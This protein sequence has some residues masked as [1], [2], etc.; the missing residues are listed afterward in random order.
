MIVVIVLFFAA[1]FILNKLFGANKYSSEAIR[2]EAAAN[3][4]SVTTG[5]EAAENQ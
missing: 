1:V 2:S 4:E 5:A 3:A